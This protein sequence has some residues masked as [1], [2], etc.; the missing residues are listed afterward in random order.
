MGQ[1]L[2][3][4][5]ILAGRPG[6]D[7]SRTNPP[8]GRSWSSRWSRASRRGQPELRAVMRGLL[9]VAVDT[10]GLMAALADLADRIQQRETRRPCTFDCPEPV[11]VADN[12]TA[13]HLYLIAQEAVHNALKHAQPKNIRIF[14]S[15]ID[16][17]DTEIAG[18]RHRHAS[19]CSTTAAWACA[20]CGTGRDHRRHA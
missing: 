9:P 8:A 20:S 14:L 7:P 1:E 11:S 15:R 19:R 18:R 12:L 5:N 13:T 6:R 3:A 17:S 10:E 2:T 16:A 4:L